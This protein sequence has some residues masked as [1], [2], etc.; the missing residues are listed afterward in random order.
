[1]QLA[2]IPLNYHDKKENKSN[3][4]YGKPNRAAQLSNYQLATSLILKNK[5]VH[6]SEHKVKVAFKDKDEEMVEERVITYHDGKHK[7][8]LL[9]LENNSS[10]C[11]L[12]TVSLREESGNSH[13]KSESKP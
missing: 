6:F 7:E 1:M 5:Q 2:H 11:E 8:M 3:H 10:N 9:T 12:N 4:K 13:A